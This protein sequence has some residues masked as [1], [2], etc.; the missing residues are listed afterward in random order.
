MIYLPPV[1]CGWEYFPNNKGLVSSLVLSGNG[2]G[3]FVFGLI[4]LAIV[5]PENQSPE[6]EVQ[7]GKIFEPTMAQS[8]RAPLMIRTNASIWALLL[9]IAVALIS[10]P[11]K[12]KDIEYEQEFDQQ[13]IQSEESVDSD[14]DFIPV[15]EEHFISLKQALLIPQTWNL[16][17]F[18]ALSTIQGFYICQVFKSYGE[19]HI[20]DDA[21][22]TIVGT[23]SSLMGF[24]GRVTWPILQDLFGFKP[25]YMLILLAQITTGLTL[26]IVCSSKTFYFIWIAIQ[27]ICYGGYFSLIPTV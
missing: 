13:N 6:L 14:N 12:E 20:A 9:I 27:Y 18:V 19:L 3:A 24:A 1:I 11:D 4:S 26:S 22:I 25:L 10:K 23:V 2:V 8:D 7:G 17:L 15:Q 21:F 5:N 16:F